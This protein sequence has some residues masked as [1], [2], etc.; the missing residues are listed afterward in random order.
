MQSYLPFSNCSAPS[1]FGEQL[2]R[3]FLHGA[4]QQTALLLSEFVWVHWREERGPDKANVCDRREWVTGRISLATRQDSSISH[5][6]KTLPP[7]YYSDCAR[8]L[9]G[10]FFS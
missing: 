4:S 6:K 10:S 8:L 5:S 7:G 2:V 3:P 1:C 9:L